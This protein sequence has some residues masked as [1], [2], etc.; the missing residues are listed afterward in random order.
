MELPRIIAK[1]KTGGESLHAGANSLGVSVLDFWQWSASDLLSNATRGRFA[2]FVVANALNVPT[3]GVRDEWSAFDLLTPEGIRVEVKSAAY[4]QAWHQRKPSNIIFSVPKTR[5]WSAETNSQEIEAR[6]QA[7]VYVFA[8]LA[9]T[10]QE[11]IDPLDV[12]QWQF[13]V[14]P[15]AILDARTRSQ[16]SITLP[17]LHQLSG[18]PVSYSDLGQK[19][20]MAA[21]SGGTAV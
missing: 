7:Q 11:T 16:H 14:L 6:R 20:R 12:D 17:T 10:N 15:T 9:H 5:A 21:G 19:V 13:F 4:I 8:L 1:R 18:G 2:E 3:N